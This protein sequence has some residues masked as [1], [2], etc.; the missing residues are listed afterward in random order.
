MVPQ[1]GLR[2]LDPRQREV[3]SRPPAPQP[4]APPVI[5]ERSGEG[6]RRSRA[7]GH[8]P[9]DACDELRVF[10]RSWVFVWS[11][12]LSVF[13]AEAKVSGNPSCITLCKK[14]AEKAGIFFFFEIRVCMNLLIRQLYQVPQMGSLNHSQSRPHPG[15]RSPRPRCHGAGSSQGLCPGR[16]DGRPLPVS[17]HSCPSAHLCP[18]VRFW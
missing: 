6:G 3:A 15:G 17:P 14:K 10:A 13:T 8:L 2:Q 11:S 12:W 1:V 5:W 18:H 7:Q 9:A 4:R 16:V